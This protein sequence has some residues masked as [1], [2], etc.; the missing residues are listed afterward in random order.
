[1]SESR[2]FKLKF[3]AKHI[4]KFIEQAFFKVKNGARLSLAIEGITK[5]LE[6]YYHPRSIDFPS[7]SICVPQL[8]SLLIRN[9][10]PFDVCVNIEIESDG[11]ENP[12]EFIEF[13]KSQITTIDSTSNHDD[14]ASLESTQSSSIFSSSS[15][16]LTRTSIKQF[17]EQCGNLE[18]LRDKTSG[19]DGIATIFNEVNG[20]VASE[21]IAESIIEN[22]FDGCRF[23]FE[24]EKL[25]IVE[26]MLEE[27]MGRVRGA[28]FSAIG[29]ERFHEKAWR[30]PENPRQIVCDQNS[31]H[32]APNESIE[33]N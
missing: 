26:I 3:L 11:S 25:H 20:I 16:H 19:A 28:D 10:L 7:S 2:T 33:V 23:N 9:E 14:E 6:I 31:F 27:I 29:F 21:E 12:L 22:L 24:I 8:R 30:V 13:F 15:S 1:M 4:G 32:V 18:H 5:P 17:M